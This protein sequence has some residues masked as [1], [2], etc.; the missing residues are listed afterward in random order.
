MRIHNWIE[1]RS[2]R[3]WIITGI[4]VLAV[5]AAFD[6]LTGYEWVWSLFYLL[7]IALLTW[8]VG[9]RAGIAA[10]IV[11]A[12]AAY[13]LDMQA[14]PSSILPA[15]YTWNGIVRLGFFLGA[16]LLVL[17]LKKAHLRA[18]QL[19]RID[20]L[21]GAV[22]ARYFSELVNMEIERTQRTQRPFSIVYVDLDNFKSLNDNLG[23]SEGDEALRTIARL[24]KSALRKVDVVAR[25]GGDEFAFLLPET[26][27]A[28]S[29]SAMA[30]LQASILDEM[31]KNNWSVTLSVG[32]LTCL[33]AAQTSDELIRRANELM[34]SAKQSGQ[35]SIQYSVDA[36]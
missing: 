7:P 23:L 2:I 9:R 30:R 5:I 36:G 19:I 20:N 4:V 34:V 31:H 14:A 32:V 35:N 8:Y 1:K 6:F 17:N 29:Q 26:N 13:L 11:S 10:S 24:A 21:T 28:G 27:Q 22:N 15:A 16:I 3:F 33:K 25:V 18:E 12:L